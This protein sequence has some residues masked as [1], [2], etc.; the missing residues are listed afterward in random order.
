MLTLQ[1]KR[2]EFQ[3][4]AD[5]TKKIEWRSVSLYNKKKLL[6]K[7]EDGLFILNN[8]V[9]ELQLING[10]RKDSPRL[11]VEVKLIEPV[12]FLIDINEPHNLFKATA[13]GHAIAIYLGEVIKKP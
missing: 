2:K 11:I 12:K 13:G 8:E 9:K 1:I 4:I 5:G 3:A 6:K 7:N 10:Y